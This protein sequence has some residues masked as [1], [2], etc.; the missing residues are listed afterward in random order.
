MQIRNLNPDVQRRHN[1]RNT[2]HTVV[3]VVGSAAIM[4]LLAYSMFGG[5]GLVVASIVGAVAMVGLGRMSPKMVLG[6]YKARPLAEQEAP[7][8]H[9]ILE[10][11]AALAKLPSKPM[12]Y[13][14]STPILNAFAVGS[15]QDAAIAVTD[16]LLR[17]MNVRQI[18]G[19]LAHE[20]SHIMN[21]DLRV[22]GM[23]DVL[24]R[25]TSFLSTLGLLGVPLIFGVGVQAPILGLLLMIFA[26]TLGGLLQLGL[27]RARE[28]D[29]DLDGATLT[30][31]PEGLASALSILEEKQGS[32][33]ES[34]ILPG[35]RLPHPSLLRTHPRTADR[36]ARLKALKAVPGERVIRSADSDQP[37]ASMVPRVRRPQVH[38][39]KLGVYY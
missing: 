4:G 23:A 32:K 38:W 18:K 12:L 31:D 13:Y 6:L 7:Q 9:A 22:M 10:E 11:L 39:H 21:G 29:A 28:Y 5:V 26:P 33:W 27:S 25:I 3:L 17:T 16:G 34:M 8:L 30:G 2:V 24:N 20:I 35:S 1:L 36:L 37:P 19:I 14:V 15:R